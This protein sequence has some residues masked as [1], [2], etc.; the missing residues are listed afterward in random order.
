MRKPLE[1]SRTQYFGAKI[2]N[3]IIKLSILINYFQISSYF[4]RVM[5]INNKQTLHLHKDCCVLPIF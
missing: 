1:N 5:I 4:S 3:Y 2:Q